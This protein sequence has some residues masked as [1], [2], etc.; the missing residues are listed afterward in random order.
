MADDVVMRRWKKM[1]GRLLR[2]GG[3]RR[4]GLYWILIGVQK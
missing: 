2:E 1:E 4:G 3:G